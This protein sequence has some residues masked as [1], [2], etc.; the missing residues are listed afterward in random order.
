VFLIATGCARKSDETRATL[1]AEQTVLA[2]QQ[3]LAATAPSTAAEPTSN[4]VT[5]RGLVVKKGWSMTWES[6][7]AGGS[8][9]YVLQTPENHS[10]ILRPS[11]SVKFGDFADYAGR[12]VEVVGFDVEPE[13]WTPPEGDG[14]QETYPVGAKAR[15]GGFRVEQIG[16]VTE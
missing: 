16:S 8:E 11:E 7:N 4:P 15:G 2:Q 1:P 3:E 6:W 12:Q 5:R 14:P 13:P 9:Y 10:M